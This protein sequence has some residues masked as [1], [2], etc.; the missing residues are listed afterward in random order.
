MDSNASYAREVEH[1]VSRGNDFVVPGKLLKMS[2]L[3][4][5]QY[6]RS[7]CRSAIP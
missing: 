3:V 1:N 5:G 4:V 7:S 6:A 2:E